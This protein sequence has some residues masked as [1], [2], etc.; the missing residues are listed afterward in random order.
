MPRA[1][2]LR[3]GY[4]AVALR[5]LAKASRNADQTRRLLALAAI[6]DGS[7]RGEAADL[8]A[9]TRQIVRDW[10]ERFNNEGPDGLIARKQ[11]GTPRR[12]SDEHRA[13][14]A[15]AVDDGPTPWRDGVVRW[16]LIDLVAWLHAWPNPEAH[17]GVSL[18]SD[19]GLELMSSDYCKLVLSASFQL[20]K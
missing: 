6:Y 17:L 11:P 2:V 8:A 7:S 12:L 13:A 1:L 20:S 10:V 4:D 19:L 9:V 14:L 3:I 5:R 18:P 16:R 15:K